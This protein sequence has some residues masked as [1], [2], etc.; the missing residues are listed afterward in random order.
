V[1]KTS[2]A[3]SAL[4]NQDDKWHESDVNW[5]EASH[6][7]LPYAALTRLWG[8]EQRLRLRTVYLNLFRD[9]IDTRLSSPINL[10]LGLSFDRLSVYHPGQQGELARAIG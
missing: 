2:R 1:V 9:K 10:A 7:E 4:A 5:H 6:E 8:Y 3:E